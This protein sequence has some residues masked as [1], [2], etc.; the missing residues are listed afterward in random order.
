MFHR[1]SRAAL[2]FSNVV[3]AL[4]TE[5][6][7]NSEPAASSTVLTSAF[8]EAD[9]S[10]KESTSPGNH[11][12]A[13]VDDL[14]TKPAAKPT[15]RIA[16][17][18][19]SVKCNTTAHSVTVADES[20]IPSRAFTSLPDLE[21]TADDLR[22]NTDRKLSNPNLKNTDLPCG[23]RFAYME[24]VTL[25]DD[26]LFY[27]GKLM[28]SLD[29][30]E[31]VLQEMK[32]HLDLMESQPKVKSLAERFLRHRYYI[33]LGEFYK[34]NKAE[35]DAATGRQQSEP[36]LVDEQNAMALETMASDEAKENE[37]S[38]T[39]T[40]RFQEFFS[41]L[42]SEEK[43]AALTQILGGLS[44][45]NA[46]LL[47][48]LV[49]KMIKDWKEEH[50]DGDA[51]CTAHRVS[52]ADGGPKTQGTLRTSNHGERGETSSYKSGG[53]CGHCRVA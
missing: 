13:I 42:S 14:T 51:H 30:D 23:E 21:Y 35:F 16:A 33:I 37:D 12:A 40:S 24:H 48:M 32:E 28:L 4:A 10:V 44:A 18:K 38:R 29:D 27:R 47:N 6:V 53:E 49:A 25:I 17:Y 15:G 19:H 22:H 43:V 45:N 20:A 26:L 52:E 36:L 41:Q 46:E 34:R 11:P 7:P 50:H 5:P 9:A 31:E 2:R 8:D 1:I 3:V 39:E